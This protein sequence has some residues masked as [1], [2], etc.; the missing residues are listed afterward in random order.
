MKHK[1]KFTKSQLK[2]MLLLAAVIVLMLGGLLLLNYFP[3]LIATGTP[4]KDGSAKAA[5]E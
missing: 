4:P 1:N 5:M 3:D 2:V